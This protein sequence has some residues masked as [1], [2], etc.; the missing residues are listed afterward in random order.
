MAVL[1]I[2]RASNYSNPVRDLAEAPIPHRVRPAGDGQRLLPYLLATFRS[3]DEAEL[4]TAVHDGRIRLADGPVLTADSVLE[5][6]QVLLADVRGRVQE[7]PFLPTP[8]APMPV[9]HDDDALFVV[10]KPPG[11]LSY[12]MGPRRV[13]AT[14]I[15]ER[16]LDLPGGALR[17]LHRLDAETS[18]VLMMART[19]EADRVVKKA[20]KRRRVAKSYLALVRGRVAPGVQI[21]KGPIGKS[22]GPIRIAMAVRDDGRPAETWIR[23]LGSFGD[24]DHGAA[25]PGYTWVEARPRTGRT[26]QIRV[27]L[28]HHGHAIVGDKVYCDGGEAFLRKWDGVMDESDLRRLELPRQA[29][30]AWSIALRHPADDRDLRLTAPPP[31]DVLAFARSHGGLAPSPPLP[32]DVPR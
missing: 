22:G 9:V 29:L 12:P 7:D 16:Q 30:H 23:N 8:L 14:A 18:G 24:T 2:P 17:P 28:A 13:A 21:L 5:A 32:L 10:D 20:F 31:A 11:L 4:R 25:G 26:H 27:H 15:A 3:A 6:G 1:P 19:L